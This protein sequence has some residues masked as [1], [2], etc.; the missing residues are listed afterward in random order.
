MVNLM[1]TAK[2]NML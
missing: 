2:Y 1:T